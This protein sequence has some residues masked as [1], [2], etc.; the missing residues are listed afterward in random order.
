MQG[1]GDFKSG[2]G[3]TT[4]IGYVNRNNQ[5]NLGTRGLAGNDHLQRAYKMECLNKGCGHIYGANG[6]DIHLR[7]CPKCSDGSPG[8]PF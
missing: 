3:K 1:S 4:A 6:S 2:D 7:R 8:L 5:K